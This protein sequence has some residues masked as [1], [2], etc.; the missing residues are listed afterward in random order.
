M[1]GRRMTRH[2]KSR[3]LMAHGLETAL[4]QE[5]KKYIS[6]PV[7]P[8]LMP[9]HVNA[10]GWCYVVA[11]YFLVEMGLKALLQ[12]RGSTPP[13]TH[14]LS[15][16]FQRLDDHDQGVLREYYEDYQATI[17]GHVGD[18]PIRRLRDFLVNL[19]GSRNE[20]GGYTGSFEWRYCLIETGRGEQMP[21]VCVEYLH[22]LAYGCIRIIVHAEN[23]RF[24]AIR[25]THSNRLRSDRRRSYDEWLEA[26]MLSDEWRMAGERW[27]VLWGPDYRGRFDLVQH[28]EDGYNEYFDEWPTSSEIPVY[29]FRSQVKR[30]LASHLG[31]K[32]G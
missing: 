10:Q 17:G 29:D 31:D 13:S 27:T 20:R 11:G 23:G 22:E 12:A 1:Q 21:F 8:D 4:D 24:H 25:Y 6:H 15:K 26:Q 7:M 19:D 3:S 32:V 30:V 18:F 28:V 2:F 14:S 16:L 9:D 5:R